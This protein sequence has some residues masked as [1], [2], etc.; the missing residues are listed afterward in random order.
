MEEYWNPL[1]PAVSSWSTFRV[2]YLA[3]DK[4]L[5]FYEIKTLNQGEIIFL[6]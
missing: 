3:L 6:S 2:R 1:D 5:V 4:V